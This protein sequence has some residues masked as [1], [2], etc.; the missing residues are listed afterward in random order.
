MCIEVIVCNVTVDFETQ[1]TT[2]FVA[3]K[4]YIIAYRM[5]A[6]QLCSPVLTAMDQ[7]LQ[8]S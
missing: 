8:K 7:K 4:N 1:C 3:K 5:K 2:P 6:A